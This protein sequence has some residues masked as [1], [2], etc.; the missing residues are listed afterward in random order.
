MACRLFTICVK[1]DLLVYLLIY[2]IQVYHYC[3]LK[4]DILVRVMISGRDETA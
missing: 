1:L 2:Y 4:V 3:L